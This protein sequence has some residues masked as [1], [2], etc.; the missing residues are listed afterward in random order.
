MPF[1]SHLILFIFAAQFAAPNDGKTPPTHIP[2]WSSAFP[3]ESPTANITFC[4]LLRSPIERQP[5][6]AMDPSPS[7]LIFV[8]YFDD[9]TEDMASPPRVPPQ[10]RIL[11]DTLSIVQA[12]FYWI[13]ACSFKM[14]ANFKAK[15]PLSPL[16][17]LIPLF[18]P[19][20]MGKPTT[21]NASPMAHGLCMALGSG[22]AMVY[23]YR[24]STHGERGK[25]RWV[26]ADRDGCCGCILCCVGVFCVVLA[27]FTH[28][29][30]THVNT[31]PHSTAI[32][33]APP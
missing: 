18:T 16:W 8:N 27:F 7:L 25:C 26:E 5:P 6:T 32:T 17:F 2:S 14:A 28:F 24:C 20:Q 21:A 9:Q 22:G 29:V 3:D 11:P 13:V 4:W 19:P 33:N 31:L 12:E 30:T 15:A 10:S 1:C 23:W